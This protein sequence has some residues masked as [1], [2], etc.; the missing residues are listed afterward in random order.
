MK[1]ILDFGNPKD[2]LVGFQIKEGK[3]VISFENL[4]RK[5]QIKIL[6]SLSNFHGLFL[7]CLKAEEE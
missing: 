2:N 3:K 7:K 6:N 1:V 4:T 5:E